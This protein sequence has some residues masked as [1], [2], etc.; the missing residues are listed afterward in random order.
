MT[1]FIRCGFISLVIVLPVLLRG[2]SKL[3]C[4]ECHPKETDAFANSFMGRSIGAPVSSLPPGKVR[5]SE[6]GSVIDINWKN[7]HLINRLSEIGFQANYPID[8]QIGAGKIGE[9]FL[10][11]EGDYLLQSPA[12]FYR[13]YGWDVSPGFK[14]AAVLDFDRVVGE[15]CLFCHSSGVEFVGRRRLASAAKIEAISCARCHGDAQ[16]H[17]QH[18]S[19]ANIVNPARLATRARDSVCEQCHLEGV[20]RVLNPGKR[21]GDFRPG[22]ALEETF[23]VYV[24]SEEQ[25]TAKV[26]SH[27]EQLAPSRC[28]RESNGKLWCGTCHN[29]HAPEVAAS[30]SGIKAVCSGCHPK[31][32]PSTHSNSSS[33]CV[34]CHMPRLNPNDI[35]HSASTDHRILA[36]PVQSSDGRSQDSL[37][38]WHSPAPEIETRNMGLAEL[39]ASAVPDLQSLGP[40][41]E[42]LLKALPADQQESDPIVLAALG[43]AALSQGQ[44]E[45]SQILFQKASHLSPSNAEYLMYLGICLKRKGDLPEAIVALQKAID[46]DNSLQ[47][48]YLELSAL[49]AKQRKMSD[50]ADVLKRYL[51]WNPQSVLIR[52]S[53]QALQ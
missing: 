41:G 29:P 20:A 16:Q 7:G 36:R 32:S 13:R 18:P 3:E 47:Q 33:D 43:D 10:L 51:S 31:L 45:L 44:I 40:Q 22:Q 14:E 39:Q 21:W 34:T 53:L 30:S 46:L 12:S 48:A 42:Q 27:A 38:A 1:S 15:Q 26:V 9:S 35:A 19:R 11:R 2:Q 52:S 37:R 23:S 4:A 17:V 6:S 25:P 5:Q 49:Y 28:A 24:R 50:A 8:Y